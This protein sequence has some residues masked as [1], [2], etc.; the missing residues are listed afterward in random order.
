M[1]SRGLSQAA[2][3]LLLA[4]GGTAFVPSK[5]GTTTSVRPSNSVEKIESCDALLSRNPGKV[6]FEFVCVL[7]WN[8]L[9]DAP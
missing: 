1:V 3:L 7:Q 9:C 5:L 8:Y 6:C 4:I 2:S